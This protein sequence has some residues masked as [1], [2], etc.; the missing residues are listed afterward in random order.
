V[1]S[2]PS[3]L[4][5]A[6]DQSFLYVALDGSGTVR[7]V[8]PSTLTAGL[9]FATGRVEEMETRP[10]DAGSVAVSQMNPNSSPRHL[11]VCLY[12]DGVKRARCTQGHTGSNSIE[13]GETGSVLYGYNNETTDFGFRT[14]GVLGDGLQELRSTG[15]LINS[16]Y[17]RIHYASGRVYS[18]NGVV[19][20]AERHVRVGTFGGGLANDA[21]PDPVLGRVFAVYGDGTLTAWDMNTFTTLGSITLPGFSDDHPANRRVRIVRW[22]TDGLAVSDGHKLFIVRTT[23]AA[24]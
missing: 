13:F 5:L 11:G 15:G 1:G 9:E 7:R 18:N 17:T 24:P 21:L 3:V 10:G 14:I 6:R 2:N 16:F 22:G 4:A 12:D 8:T 20:D 19:I 23:L